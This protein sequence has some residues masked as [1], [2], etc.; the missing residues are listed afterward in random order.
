[1]SQ[2]YDI[3]W[4]KWAHFYV[5]TIGEL[6]GNHG[7]TVGCILDIACG[8][9]T[10]AIDL[11]KRGNDILR[12]DLSPEM[13][14]I[15]RAKAASAMLTN[16]AF[17]TADMKSFIPDR[18]FD[19]ALCTYDSLNYLLESRALIST[20]QNVSFALTPG[21]FFVFDFNTE[22][23]YL[24]HHKGEC[25]RSIA[26]VDFVQKLSY[27][28]DSRIANTIFEFQNG[29][30]E[31]HAQRA[32]SITEVSSALAQNHMIVEEFSAD[33]NG[34]PC[35]LDTERVYCIAKKTK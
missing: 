22:A 7:K 2:F 28:A 21:G 32:L 3:E 8:T 13:I 6:L 33:L 25:R 29:Q 27:S 11:A 20:F 4:G 24:S 14:A 19:G 16:I 26:G 12:I 30:Y 1:M 34:R 5:S 35:Q 23:M 18:Q 17:Q 31:I 10:L 9:G 15:A